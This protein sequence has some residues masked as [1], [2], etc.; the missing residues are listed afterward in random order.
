MA[1]Q[2]NNRT[3]SGTAGRAAGKQTSAKIVHSAYEILQVG[4]YADFS[5]RKIADKAGIR[6]ANLQYYFPRMENLIKAL[7]DHVGEIYDAR[8]ALQLANTGENPLARFKAAIE[9]NI[10]DVS[11]PATRHFFI[12][13]WPFLGVADNY[14]GELMVE[15]YQPQHHQMRELIKDLNPAMRD[16]D[17]MLRAE[18]ITAL[19]EGLLVTTVST[20]KGNKHT[21]NLK[22]AIMRTSLDIAQN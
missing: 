16:Q 17:V 22:Q 2:K 12:Q 1:S 10:E 9:L 13:F 19:F 20:M 11:D 6:L 14:T 5:M 18:M 21:Q 8:Y 3:R 7:M 4:G 15:F